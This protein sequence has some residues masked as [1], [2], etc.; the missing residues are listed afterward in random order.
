MT[1]RDATNPVPVPDAYGTEVLCASWNPGVSALAD[2][3]ERV[4]DALSG[5]AASDAEAFLKRLYQSQHA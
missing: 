2:R 4:R 3:V 5:L 1:T